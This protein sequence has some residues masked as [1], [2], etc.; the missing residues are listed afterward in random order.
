MG[1]RF[2]GLDLAAP[3]GLLCDEPVVTW[4]DLFELAVRLIPAPARSVA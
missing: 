2:P 1:D 3:A 4:N